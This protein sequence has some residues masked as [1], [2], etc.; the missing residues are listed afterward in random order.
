M[1]EQEKTNTWQGVGE[2]LRGTLN[3]TVDERFP[4]K[5]PEK[6]AAANAQ[7]AAVLERGRNEMEGIPHRSH[8][9]TEPIPGNGQGY[10]HY[11]SVP[12]TSPYRNSLPPDPNSNLR[13]KAAPGSHS[14]VFGL[15]HDGTRH[16]DTSPSLTP[17]RQSMYDASSV[18]N[19][20]NSSGG[21]SLH[22][23]PRGTA[24]RVDSSMAP[25]SLTGDVERVPSQ[26]P[27][28]PPGTNQA[29]AL[30]GE[31]F[32]SPVSPVGDTGKKKGTFSKLFKRKPVASEAGAAEGDSKKYY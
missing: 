31:D 20:T 21:H 28:P 30:S 17:A 18:S 12:E 14:A 29:A 25:E 3:S 11:T 7:N 16:L 23:A 1:A 6:A 19:L 10:T 4:R 26:R 13:G 24:V 9:P 27:P 8:Q 15:T 5:N 22:F 2:T 32:S